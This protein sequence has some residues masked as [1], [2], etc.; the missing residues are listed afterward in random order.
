MSDEPA[1]DEAGDRDPL[2]DDPFARLGDDEI[3]HDADADALFEE[4][5]ISP[6]DEE[7]V[8]AAIESDGEAAGETAVGASNGEAVVPK[9]RYCT[10]CE[11]FS[12]PPGAACTNPGTEIVEL[13]G[14][15]SFRVRNCPVV[16]RRREQ[17][18]FPD[19]S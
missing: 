9:E 12:E 2:A 4:M 1:A 16:E 15:D 6:L 13:V 17:A 3:E 5:D 14:V 8:W 19:E 18:V 11:H 7:A 10:T